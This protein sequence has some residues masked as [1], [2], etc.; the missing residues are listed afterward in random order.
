MTEYFQKE[1][2]PQD[3]ILTVFPPP[4]P[5]LERESFVGCVKLTIPKMTILSMPEIRL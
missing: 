3:E 2:E 4:S 5:L 1:M